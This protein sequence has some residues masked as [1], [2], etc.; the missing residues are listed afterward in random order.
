M[1]KDGSLW[2]WGAYT[3]DDKHMYKPVHVKYFENYNI[4]KLAG[5]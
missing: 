3:P 4:I 2:G 5:W 1:G